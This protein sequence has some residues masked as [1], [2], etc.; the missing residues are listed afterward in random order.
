[1]KVREFHSAKRGLTP[2]GSFRRTESQLQSGSESGTGKLAA[3]A[4]KHASNNHL[5]AEPWTSPQLAVVASG[6]SHGTLATIHL[7][8]GQSPEGSC[9]LAAERPPSYSEYPKPTACSIRLPPSNFTHY[10]TLSSKFFS[11]FPHGTCS[12]SVSHAYLALD[13]VYH[14]FRVAL[15]SNSTPGRR[16][17][18]H[19]T[20]T[21]AYHP[22]REGAAF[23]RTWAITQYVKSDAPKHHIPQRPKPSSSVLGWS[24]FA[25]RY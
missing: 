14:P 15:T 19:T 18:A 22:L 7:Q 10:L 20:A 21:R 23:Q 4:R 11:T 13:G 6:K 25:R 12:L 8:L 1:M 3:V 16:Q 2:K 9:P 17:H 24:P 5:R